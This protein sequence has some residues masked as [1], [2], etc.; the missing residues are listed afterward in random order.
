M[1]QRHK[2]V[3]YTEPDRAVPQTGVIGLQIHAGHPG[4]MWHKDITLRPLP[5]E[6]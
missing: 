1:S 3:D 6:K 4:E 2:T 5:A